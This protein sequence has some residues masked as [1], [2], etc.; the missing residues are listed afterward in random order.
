VLLDLADLD[1]LARGCGVLAGGG[2]G[3]ARTGLIVARAAIRRF[4]PVPLVD[5]DDLPDDALVVP[6]GLAGSPPVANEKLFA[7]DEPLRLAEDVERAWGRPADALM[8]LEI[9]GVNGLY[10][11][12]W[13]ARLRLPYV[14]ADGM[15]RALPTVPQMAMHLAGV[16]PSPFVL[17]D[18]RANT[19][20][21]RSGSAAWIEELLRAS[22]T[23]MGGLAACAIYLMPAATARSAVIRGSVTRALRIGRA[24]EAAA[25]PV[26]AAR[27]AT[28]AIELVSGRVIDVE[29]R[30]SGGFARGS[31]I[32]QEAGGEGGRLVRLELQNENLVALADGRV[33]ATVPDVITVLDAYTGEVIGTDRLRYGQRVVVLAFPVDAVWRSPRGLEV[34]GPAAFGIDLPFVPVEELHAA[35]P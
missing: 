28:G 2:G 29:R 8:P 22:L 23:T 12:A 11:L 14:D 35:A 1:A 10:P 16:S 5:L 33:L 24:M 32:I 34:A 20:V 31:A 21:A 30:V 27:E 9:A 18:E 13:A 3:D 19:I 17:T 7:G 15:G 26:Q 6:A 25:D 4:G